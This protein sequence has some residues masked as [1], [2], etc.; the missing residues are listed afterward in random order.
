MFTYEWLGLPSESGIQPV[1]RRSTL[2]LR[3]IEVAIAHA[4]TELKK[5]E[6]YAGKQT[7]GIRVLN[8][9]HVLVWT[10]NIEDS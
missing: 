4:K 10:G 2:S 5:K 8:N 3:S 9:H 6:A 7:Y 1:L